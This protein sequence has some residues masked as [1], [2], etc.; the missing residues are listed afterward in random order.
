MKRLLFSTIFL[1]VH[2]LTAFA[3]TGNGT[4]PWGWCRWMWRS[5]GGGFMMILPLLLVIILLYFFMKGR[6]GKESETPRADTPMEI[7]KKRY[8]QGEI[9]KE[10]FEE[11]KKN[12]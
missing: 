1:I 5:G 6:S 9:T 12:L 4:G 3:D 8:A 11:M 2:P 10:Q 7:L